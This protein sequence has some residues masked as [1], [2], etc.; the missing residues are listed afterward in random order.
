[1]QAF[2]WFDREKAKLEFRRI[3][4]PTGHVI[5]IWNSRKKGASPFLEAYENLLQQF[6]TD[7]SAVR[8]VHLILRLYWPRHDVL[9]GSW[10]PPPIVRLGS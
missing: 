8:H 6:A 5:L 4:K 10:T 7:Y 1:M 2:H 9:T 3:L